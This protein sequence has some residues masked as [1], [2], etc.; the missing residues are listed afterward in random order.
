MHFAQS[1]GLQHVVA[2]L[3]HYAHTRG[4]A[5]GYWTTAPLLARLA[6]SGG[7]FQDMSTS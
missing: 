5:H 6:A 7:R 4:N 2:R 1:E 3:A